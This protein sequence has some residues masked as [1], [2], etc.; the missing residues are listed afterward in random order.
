MA[1]YSNARAMDTIKFG[2]SVSTS[3]RYALQGSQALAG[4]RSWARDTNANG[5]VKLPGRSHAARVNL[6]LYDDAS[7]SSSAGVN[8]ENSRTLH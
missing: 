5:G 2:A 4:L 8:T 1:E 7:S 6:V 3:G